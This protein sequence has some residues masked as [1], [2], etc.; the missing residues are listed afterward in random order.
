MHI[1]ELVTRR[2]V[3]VIMF[4][5]GILLLGFVS[6]GRL[7]VDLLP[8]LSYPKLTVYT[9]FPNAVP[10]EVERLITKPIEQS[11]STVAG[12]RKIRS[13]SKEGLSQIILEFNW[14]QNMDFASLH[15]REKLDAISR[16]LPEDAGRPTLIHL[17]P[18]Q[19]PIIALSVSGRDL[20]SLKEISRNVFKRRLEQIRGVA[21]ADVV[22]GMEREVQV[23]VDKEKIEA[24]G[25]TID[26]I[27]AAI[28]NA[29][30]DM[31]GGTIK[32]GRYR[33]SLRTIGSFQNVKEM[34][35]VVIKRERDGSIIHLRDVAV[36]KQ[37]FKE[38]QNI[39]HYNGEESIGILL[40]KEAGANTVRVSKRVKQVLSQLR[41]EYPRIPI[42]IAYDQADFISKAVSNVLQAIVLGGILAF[43]ILFFFM[44]DI[45][46][47][48]SISVAIPISIIGTFILLYFTGVSLNL[49]SLGGLALGVGM[50]VD[51]SIVVLEN[52]FRHR[53][54]GA[55]MVR[56]AVNG[57]KEVAMAV[58]A[59]TF[60][61]IAVFF[62]VLYVRGIAGQLFKDQA[63]TVTFALLS[64]LVVSLTLLPV[65]AS[66]FS[67]DG[68]VD[69][70]EEIGGGKIDF[71]NRR[72]IRWIL[73]PF[74]IVLGAIFKLIRYIYRIVMSLI[75]LI[76]KR[77]GAM[78]YRFTNPIFKQ[79]N[80]ILSFL[81]QKYEKVLNTA[82]DNRVAALLIMALIL[83]ITAGAGFILP[84]ELMP[85]VDQR[86]F[87]I[88]VRMEPGTS[89]SAVNELVLQMEREIMQTDGV[90][91]VFSSVGLI[92]QQIGTGMANTGLNK[93]EIRVRVKRGV[94][95]KSIMDNLRKRFANSAAE[96]TFGTGQTVLSQILGTTE[97]DIVIQVY[98]EKLEEA[99]GII[100]KI[101][102]KCREVPGI[103]DLKSDF[104]VG[105]PEYRIVI[106]RERA[107]MYGLSVR[108][109]A[110]F[111]KND[112]TGDL[113]SQFKEMEQKIDIRVKPRFSNRMDIER[114]MNTTIP[115]GHSGIPLREVATISKS[116]GAVEIHREDQTRVISLYANVSGKSLAQ[117][118]KKLEN[119]MD[120]IPLSTDTYISIGGAKQEMAQSYKSLMWAGILAIVLVYMIMA[121]QF[122]SLIHPLIIIF[123][124]PM[125]AVGTIWLLLLT[126]QSLNVISM[127]GV[128]VLVGIAVNDAIVKIDFINQERRRGSSVRRAIM[129]AGR[130]RF[131]PI[132]M[133]S[134]TTILGLAP[135]ASGLG[136]GAELQR[137]LAL[138]IIGGLFTS[139]VLTLIMIPVLYSLVSERRQSREEAV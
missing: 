102:E 112:L 122:E 88:E 41:M 114:L 59:S 10:E 9:V 120:D 138:A 97:A 135:M 76:L 84:R 82:L 133:T 106:D 30:V 71:I 123:S 45:R 57:T 35:S 136:A 98:G 111:I 63:I 3:A 55:G 121:A 83:F 12:I 65:L 29:N 11:V 130:K 31:P 126:G 52:I 66:R 44:N 72:P 33:Y 117:V 94:K 110:R 100:E 101:K 4:Y 137:P 15:V 105:R 115:T 27:S 70:V 19:Q 37:G 81:M 34:E 74:R 16:S 69:H 96:V 92:R 6:L 86:E 26:H 89:L 32:K 61:T 118:I 129:D 17:D 1:A 139:T 107:G 104:E 67:R 54:G 108:N 14:G 46:N 93:A 68:K 20:V 132:V 95:T 103:T 51:C 48:L 23:D 40:T 90:Q 21:L 99:L 128:V 116:R 79:F 28:D 49:M 127:I 36:V 113:A 58:T 60:T 91:D 87:R 39:T 131:R 75:S 2:P 50:L 13:F 8:D 38:R 7:S 24:L 85:R 73:F 78:F 109:I 22:G 5:T 80:R 119:K 53:E 25:L 134:V 18:S 42:V 77:C 56:A 62:P 64:S 47:P 124:I 43:F 125:A